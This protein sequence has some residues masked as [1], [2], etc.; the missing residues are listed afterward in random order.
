MKKNITVANLT[1][2]PLTT[3]IN[4]LLLWYDIHNV[5]VNRLDQCNKTVAGA[6]GS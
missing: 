3:D 1:K 5:M 6:L 2:F 4:N